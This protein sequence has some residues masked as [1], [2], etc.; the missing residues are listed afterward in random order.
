MAFEEIEIIETSTASSHTGVSAGLTKVR[1]GK[2][3]LKINLRPHVF[4][5]MGFSEH[6]HFVPMLGTGEDF[7][8]V[9]L[10]KNKNGKLRAKHRSAAHGA[11]YFCIS[12]R[13]RPEFVDRA[14]KAVPCQWEKIDLTTI[15][16]VLPAWTDE[17]NP[18]KRKRIAAEP[19]A[20]AAGRREA[21]RMRQEAE[22]ARRRR[23][24]L[25]QRGLEREMRKVVA[26]ALK[27]VPEFKSELGLS[28]TEAEILAVLAN[29]HGKLVS[30][31]S[32]MTLV[33]AADAEAVPDD[34][35]IDV[36]I[37]KIRPKLPISCMIETVRGQGW[38]LKGDVKQ[39]YAVVAA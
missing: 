30:K 31:E 9:R 10:Q 32:L 39:L 17:T 5:E 34:K 29:R 33:Y 37:C 7:G 23:D 20:I 2:A 14:E 6:D 25:E 4:Q 1:N 26:E 13:H 19:P 35:V 27:D 16:I 36:W 8:M 15:E 12:L 28:K 3:L 22:E 38:R 24:E 18:T 21:E 11:Q